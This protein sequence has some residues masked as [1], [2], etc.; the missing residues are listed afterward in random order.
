MALQKTVTSASG[1]TVQDAYIKIDE[2]TCDKNNTV[3]ATVQAYVNKEFERGGAA[4][5]DGSTHYVALQ[6]DYADDSINAKKQIY[7]HI[8]KTNEYADAIDV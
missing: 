4:P 2:Y 5:I 6:V 1:L 7:E 8:K 3:H